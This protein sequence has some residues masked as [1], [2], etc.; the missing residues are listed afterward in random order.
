MNANRSVRMSV[1]RGIARMA[2]PRRIEFL[3]KLNQHAEFAKSLP[4]L[5]N[6]APEVPSSVELYRRVNDVVLEN[7]PIDYL[8]FG[9]FKG[10]SMRQWTSLNQH[11]RSRFAG[12]DT[13]TGLPEDWTPA[14]RAGAFNA[15]GRAP[16]FDDTRVQFVTG[17]FQHTLVDFLKSFQVKNRLVIHVDCDL[18]SATL[19]CLATLDRHM[20][21]GT[22]IIFDEFYNLLHEFAAFRDYSK[23]FMRSAQGIAYT[24]HYTQVALQL[25]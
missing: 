11:P 5:L 17:L 22:L 2:F 24:H 13:F 10:W 16:Q 21:S 9:V 12:F 6:G 15:D 23:A 18:Y 8:E 20:P 19:F 14:K 4:K 3:D 1:K 7:G 25:G